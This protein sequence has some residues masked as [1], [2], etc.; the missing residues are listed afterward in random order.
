MKINE[1]IS[2]GGGFIPRNEKEAHDPRWEM[3]M[4]CDIRP[5]QDRKEANKFGLKVGSKGPKI[6]RTNGLNEDKQLDLQSELMRKFPIKV[7][8]YHETGIEHLDNILKYGLGSEEGML[9]FDNGIEGIFCT[10]GEPS[11]FI[12]RGPKA[13]IAFDVP[14]KNYAQIHHDMRYSSDEVLL[15]EHPNLIGADVYYA[16]IITKNQIK[17]IDIKNEY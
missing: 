12:V 14:A 6:M 2:E 16:G 9:D 3:A 1:I 13:V 11:N 4:T 17:I 15:K 5:G 7:T 10:I 8:L